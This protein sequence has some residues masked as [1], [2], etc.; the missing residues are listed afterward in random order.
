MNDLVAT[1][2]NVFLGGYYEGD[3]MSIHKDIDHIPDETLYEVEADCFFCLTNLVCGIQ[4]HFIT[5]Q[6]GLQ[7]MILH[8]IEVINLVDKELF[9]HLQDSGVEISHFA[10][11][12]MNCLLVR[13]LS[14]PCVVRLWDTYLSE[15]RGFDEFHVYVCAAFLRHFK[16]KL[17]CMGYEELFEFLTVKIQNFTEDSIEVLHVEH[18]LGQAYIWKS[19]FDARSWHVLPTKIMPIKDEPREKNQSSVI[20]F[21][22]PSVLM[23]DVDF[24]CY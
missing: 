9:Q 3:D 5:E 20:N 24:L 16:S 12:W 13:E 22:I 19:M 1:L 17:K 6:P 23:Y 18:W 14:L 8:F 4:D 2:F 11:R 15:D 10:F 21:T 7:R